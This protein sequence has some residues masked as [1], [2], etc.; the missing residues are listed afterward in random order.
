[1]MIFNRYLIAIRRQQRFIERRTTGVVAVRAT[2]EH[3]RDLVSIISLGLALIDSLHL[4]MVTF[5]LHIDK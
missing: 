2:L 1:M 5:F 3:I 4:L